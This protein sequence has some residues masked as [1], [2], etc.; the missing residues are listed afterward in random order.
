MQIM[1][2]FRLSMATDAKWPSIISWV[3]LKNLIKYTGSFFKFAASFVLSVTQI[4]QA[5][6]ECLSSWKLAEKWQE[7][8]YLSSTVIFFV[9]G[10]I[11]QNW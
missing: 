6:P 1:V 5:V 2:L 9:E 4:L 10:G 3:S 7:P 8:A 11:F